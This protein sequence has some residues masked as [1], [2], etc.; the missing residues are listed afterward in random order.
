MGHWRAL[1]WSSS[2]WCYWSLSVQESG[3]EY[4]L[5]KWQRFWTL[6][7]WLGIKPSLEPKGQLF[8]ENVWVKAICSQSEEDES[9]SSPR[10]K[11]EKKT[12]RL[13]RNTELFTWE[14]KGSILGKLRI[15]QQKHMRD[16]TT[17]CSHRCQ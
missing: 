12:A 8:G 4:D 6:L 9:G 14:N 11:L 17:F 5:Q 13:I 2:I 10:G 16:A 7:Y 3:C 15:T 1:S